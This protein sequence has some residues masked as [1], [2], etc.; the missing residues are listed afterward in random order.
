MIFSDPVNKVG[1]R[2]TRHNAVRHDCQLVTRFYGVT[3]WLVRLQRISE[4]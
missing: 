4:T 2:S 1:L 3:S